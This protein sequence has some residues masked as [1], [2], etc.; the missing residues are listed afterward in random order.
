MEAEHWAEKLEGGDGVLLKRTR[1]ELVK[2]IGEHAAGHVKDPEVTVNTLLKK[3]DG[4]DMVRIISVVW[5]NMQEKMRP[6]SEEGERRIVTTLVDELRIN[7]GV[8]VSQ[9][10]DMAREGGKVQPE[11]K[12]AV[13][14]ASNADRVGD[15]I[16]EMGK[17]V[18][19]ITK[20]GWRPSKKGVDEMMKMMAG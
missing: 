14:G 11:Y 13:L 15:V 3:V 20:G 10:L 5:S 1:S 17:D 9:S 4:Y 12:Y 7:F 18:L 2:Q 19:K 8:R 16:K 6:L